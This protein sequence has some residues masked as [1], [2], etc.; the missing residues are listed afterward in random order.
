MAGSHETVTTPEPGYA[1][2]HSGAI[3]NILAL[4]VP[5]VVVVAKWFLAPGVLGGSLAACFP[6][7]PWLKY[8]ALGVLIVVLIA[9]FIFMVGAIGDRAQR[10][11]GFVALGL[12]LAVAPVTLIVL[13]L[14]TYG[15]PGPGGP[16]CVSEGSLA[17]VCY[18]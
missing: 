12:T 15:D 14:M 10:A 17:R 8:L 9:S 3:A 2:G 4:V 5:P 16:N 11:L 18:G 1:R 6:G 13:F 7:A